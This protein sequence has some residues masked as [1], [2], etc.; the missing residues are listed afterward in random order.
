M[1]LS[2]QKFCMLFYYAKNMFKGRKKVVEKK[3]EITNEEHFN[4]PF[5]HRIKALKSFGD[6]EEGDI[7]GYIEDEGNLSQE[8]NSWVYDNACVMWGAKVSG[9]AA[10]RNNAIVANNSMVSDNAVVCGEPHIYDSQISGNAAVYDEATV[11]KSEISGSSKVHGDAYIEN[12]HVSGS[13]EISNAEKYELTNETIEYKGRTLHRIRALRSFD[14]VKKGDLGGFVENDSSLYRGEHHGLSHK[15]NAWI[16]DNAKVMD[17]AVVAG[18]AKISDNAEVYDEAKVYQDARVFGHAQVFNSA[19][20]TNDAQV[21][22]NA[23][24]CANECVEADMKVG[25]NEEYNGVY[26]E[27][28]K[29]KKYE[30]TDETIEY[31]GRTLHRIRALRSFDDVKKGDLG[32]FVEND[33]S[34]YRNGLPGLSHK[35]NAWVYNN[36]KV[37]DH[38][39]VAGNAR[40]LDDAEVYGHAQVFDSATV[41]NVAQVFDN[42]QVFKEAYV[43]TDMK[44]GGNEELAYGFNE[45]LDFDFSSDSEDYSNEEQTDINEKDPTEENKPEDVY[46]NSKVNILSNSYVAEEDKEKVA[47]YDEYSA[48]KRDE[49]FKE[50]T[51]YVNNEKIEHGSVVT[52]NNGDIMYLEYV[53]NDLK[54]DEAYKIYPTNEVPKYAQSLK[55]TD[56]KFSGYSVVLDKKYTLNKSSIKNVIGKTSTGFSNHVFSAVEYLND[57]HLIKDCSTP[58]QKIRHAVGI[59]NDLSL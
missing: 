1:F 53:D 2:V 37:M 10:V 25:G 5:L 29:D 23:E 13:T 35:G 21:F 30:L 34:L 56:E 11:Y 46:G 39:V 32:G 42:A 44:V 40:I 58:F 54:T 48:K 27:P 31:K 6:V 51:A 4:S 26:V 16:Y 19:T 22:D 7:G 38:A 36:A 47:I 28:E 57:K 33:S 43:E 59:Y 41:R 17:Q 14:D 55:M 15:A 24:V 20:V 52:Y 9:D 49:E 45:Y 50:F 18:N 8:G 3:Y 12:R